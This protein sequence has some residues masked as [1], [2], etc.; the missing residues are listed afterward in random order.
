MPIKNQMMSRRH[1]VQGSD[2]IRYSA[3]MAPSGA[4]MNTAGVLNAR[5]KLGSRTR[6]TTM[7][8]DTITNAS[9]V[10]IDTNRPASDTVRREA[11]N[12]TATPVMIDEIYALWNRGYAFLMNVGSSPPRAIE[13]HTR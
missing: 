4:T 6:S 7:P 10:P 9:S 3:D 12:A 1:V 8:M 2:A 11:T 13:Q 5:G